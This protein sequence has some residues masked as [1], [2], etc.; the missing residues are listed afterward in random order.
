[1]VVK[2]LS[3]FGWV[4]DVYIVIFK[5]VRNGV[6]LKNLVFIRVFFRGWIK[7]YFISIVIFDDE[8]LNKEFLG[9]FFL[10]G[11]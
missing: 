2:R 7:V 11:C 4:I 8:K 5:Y 10:K 6:F 9:T 1:M 3:G